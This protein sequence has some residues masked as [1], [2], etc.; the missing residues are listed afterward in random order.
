[1]QQASAASS[2]YA[3][4]VSSSSSSLPTNSPVQSSPHTSYP[5]LFSNVGVL[6]SSNS[7]LFRPSTL[8]QPS[9]SAS[10]F[11]NFC[12]SGNMLSSDT[13]SSFSH[14]MNNSASLLSTD[15]FSYGNFSMNSGASVTDTSSS[16]P[17]EHLR[18]SITPSNSQ[19]DFSQ[20]Y[21][22]SPNIYKSQTGVPAGSSTN[23]SSGITSN[24]ITRTS[25][26]ESPNSSSQTSLS[27]DSSTLGPL[28][29]IT[30]IYFTNGT[31]YGSHN[32]ND[33]DVEPDSLD[34]FA[35]ETFAQQLSEYLPSYSDGRDTNVFDGDFITI[36]T[37][38]GDTITK[39]SSKNITLNSNFVGND[40]TDENM[41]IILE[42]PKYPRY[43]TLASR[44]KSFEKVWPVTNKMS[45][46]KL[47]EAG[48][49][50]TG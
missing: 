5:S 49:V 35:D 14:S 28:S 44:E 4:D 26:Y 29:N 20:R 45:W 13:T 40:L 17:N 50:Y 48:F 9:A 47:P 16:V 25:N 18:A 37:S 39:I 32:W 23:S 30:S 27:F 19:F 31:N 15:G 38:V 21:R 36:R 22:H 34:L 33:F 24:S 41:G 10:A 8:T 1:M 7:S 46:K 6:T 2:L 42:R 3:F 43:A 11:G 12:Y